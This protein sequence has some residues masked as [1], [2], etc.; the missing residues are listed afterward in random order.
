MRK[1]RWTMLVLTVLTVLTVFPVTASAAPPGGDDY[2]VFICPAVNTRRSP[3]RSRWPPAC[4]GGPTTIERS[5]APLGALLS[6]SEC[7]KPRS[8]SRHQS[9][10]RWAPISRYPAWRWAVGRV[11]ALWLVS[12]CVLELHTTHG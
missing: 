3:V 9:A 4:S 12:G 8:R 2:P 5:G 1:N 10:P 6:L 11:S 7:E